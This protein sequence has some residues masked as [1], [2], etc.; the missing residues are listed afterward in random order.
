MALESLAIRTDASKDIR[1]EE[2]HS[3]MLL[4][5]SLSA[6]SKKL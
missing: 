3:S 1:K 6:S 4:L 5:Y 2:G